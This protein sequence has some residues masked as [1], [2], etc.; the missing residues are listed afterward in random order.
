M[1]TFYHGNFGITSSWTVSYGNYAYISSGPST[2]S[3]TVSFNTS[4]MA[5]LAVTSAV[6]YATVGYVADGT[7]VRSVDGTWFTGAKNV[8]I[9]A[10]GW[11]SYTFRFKSSGSTAGGPGSYSR[12]LNFSN[13][14]LVVN[15][16]AT[17]GGTD[18]G[19][20]SYSSPQYVWFDNTEPA[21]PGEVRAL[22]WT[23]GSAHSGRYVKGY[24]IHRGTSLNNIA[25]YSGTGN[26]LSLNVPAPTANNTSFYYKVLTIQDDNTY[27]MYSNATGVITTSF[28]APVV[29]GVN[30]NGV[31]DPL[32]VVAGENLTL[33]WSASNGVRNG[34]TG[35]RIYRNGVHYTDVGV[36]YSLTV[37]SHTTLGSSYYYSVQ[38]KA[39]YEWSSTVNGPTVYSY[40]ACSAPTSISLAKNNV[41]PGESV[42]L[43][44]SGAV[45]G[46]QYNAI[47]GYAIYRAIGAVGEFALLSEVSATATSGTLNVLSP[48]ENEG[49]YR[50]K[51]V[52]KG[53]RLN[54]GQSAAVATLTT[55]F[56]APTISDVKVSKQYAASGETVTLSWVVG[57]GTNNPVK[58][59]TVYRD[60][61]EYQVGVSGASLSVPA[62][63]VA[64]EQHQ[65]SVK[66]IGTYLDGETLDAQVLHTYGDPV[67]PNVVSVLPLS[68]DAGTNAVLSW[69]GASAGAKN[70]I[71]GYQVFR[72][73]AV[74]GPYSL[75]QEITSTETSGNYTVVAHSTMGSSYF[76]KVLVVG[77]YS[78]SLESEAT[79][80]LKSIVYTVVKA[81][82]S[83][84]VSPVEVDMGYPATLSWSGAEGGTN[85]P[86]TGYR[87]FRSST[88]TGTYT[89]L[90]EVQGVTST[91]V[92]ASTTM[93]AFY[94]YKVETVGTKTGFNLSGQSTVY[95]ALKTWAFTA[96]SAPTG[97]ALSAT[98]LNP[99][100]S[101]RLSWNAAAGGTNTTVVSYEVYKTTGTTYVLFATVTS[102]VLFVDDVIGPSGTAQLYKIKSIADR[103][104]WD[105]GFSNVVTVKSN[106][107]PT[108]PSSV[109]ATPALYESGGITVSFPAAADMDG[110]LSHYQV[111]RR[112]Q[113]EASGWGPWTNHTI[114]LK[115]L[116][117]VDHAEVERGQRVQYQV[118]T[119]DALGLV[120]AYTQS[121]QVLRNS[122][123]PLPVI[124]LPVGERIIYN[125]K[126]IIRVS[127]GAEVNGTTQSLQMAVDSGA[128]A[129]M[130]TL[131]ASGGVMPVQVTNALSYGLHTIK[132]R[133][134][135]NLGAVSEVASVEIDIRPTEYARGVEKGS[136]IA[137]Q[138]ISHQAE[139]EQLYAQV[140]DIRNYYGYPKILV[141]DSV[142]D[143]VN[144]VAGNIGMFAAWGDQMRSLQ[145]AIG[146]TWASSGIT[147]ATWLVCKKGMH[148]SAAVVAQIRREIERA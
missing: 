31:G 121:I 128:F 96:V 80:E 22:R 144:V 23:A 70:D 41:A 135:D 15:E 99:G 11:S 16:G 125:V 9:N 92:I 37:P 32:Y 76:Y 116:S 57:N 64:G 134:M 44:W 114:E 87:I 84:S 90:K 6:L 34:I 123:P 97:V 79:A 75:L 111:Q 12:T 127:V 18:P 52:T 26:V 17:G 35:F 105:S 107:P 54:S 39:P 8:S 4:S 132:V 85:N 126:P 43:N 74:G 3:Y 145:V 100:A 48:L 82:T 103:A 86:I 94:Y 24:D 55:L 88:P 69:S 138:S 72:A 140:N 117:L 47:S 59:V 131:P 109:N 143:H 53:Q 115:G 65:Y 124:L 58:S 19:G 104:G 106:T 5:G 91:E 36:V 136:V 61:V 49:I 137:N 146:E 118:K 95:A 14:R 101:V 81:P 33:T 38:A 67:A 1:A 25:W 2:G 42:A 40:S 119:H 63:E 102:D 108:A 148:P 7:S 142:G 27:Y 68:V 120:S 93:G 77:T 71:K 133:M 129:T 110:N 112:I 28:S 122:L 56:T 113:T 62:H 139:I 30:L 130:R 73:T 78:N 98:I 141:P 29:A 83:V 20:G 50:Y 60:G 51:V 66:V 46:S 13:V 147:P 21:Y 89:L 45:N 10:S